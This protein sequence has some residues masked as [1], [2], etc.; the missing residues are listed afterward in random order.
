MAFTIFFLGTDTRYTPK[1]EAPTKEK[2]MDSQSSIMEN[3]AP[4]SQYRTSA[5]LLA[6]KINNSI[7][8]TFKLNKLNVLCSDYLDY[9]RRKL[10]IK[11]TEPYAPLSASA[12]ESEKIFILK[13][14]HNLVL[15]LYQLT[16]SESPNLDAFKNELNGDTCKTL[17]HQHRD[18]IFMRL[19]ADL[20]GVI[21][22]IPRLLFYKSPNG[23]FQHPCFWQP[24]SEVLYKAL[25][26]EVEHDA[27]SPN[28]PAF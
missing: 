9:A 13:Q 8:N 3:H 10:H 1:P 5:T 21:A 25:Q 12:E 17:L 15:K 24:H 26:V 28:L 18:N 14:K 4:A 6:N 2:E 20:W 23:L 19:I 11:P 22:G 16:R 7:P 27:T